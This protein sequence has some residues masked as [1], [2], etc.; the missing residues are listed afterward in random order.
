MLYLLN[1]S[2]STVSVQYMYH[3]P[4]IYMNWIEIRPYEFAEV[5]VCVSMFLVIR[6]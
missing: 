2:V 4:Q 5:C 3:I 6:K 1:I